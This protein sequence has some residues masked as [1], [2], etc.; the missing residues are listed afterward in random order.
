M[1]AA[2]LL[3]GDDLPVGLAKPPGM[4]RLEVLANIL[5]EVRMV[6]F[7]RQNVITAAGD[8]LGGDLFLAACGVDG[9]DGVLQVAF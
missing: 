8:D 6:V 5:T 2:A 3:L 7:D 1:P 9:E 4:P